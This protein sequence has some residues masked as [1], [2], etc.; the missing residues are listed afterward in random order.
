ML[1]GGIFLSHIIFLNRSQQSRWDF[2]MSHGV[3]SLL[4]LLRPPVHSISKNCSSVPVQYRSL[5]FC[6]IYVGHSVISE[7]SIVLLHCSC[8]PGLTENKRPPWG[9][10]GCLAT[11][12]LGVLVGHRHTLTL[13]EDRLAPFMITIQAFTLVHDPTQCWTN[14]WSVL[15]MWFC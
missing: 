15:V 9:I 14:E 12:S 8:L 6:H 11:H 3:V 2:P 10:V 4:A 13:C 7:M 1:T 5:F